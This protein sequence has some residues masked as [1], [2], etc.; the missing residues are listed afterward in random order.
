[1]FVLFG[2]IFRMHAHIKTF[3]LGSRFGLLLVKK[4]EKKL[5]LKGLNIQKILIGCKFIINHPV[6]F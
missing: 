3:S 5:V 4:E 2:T 1:M 6:K